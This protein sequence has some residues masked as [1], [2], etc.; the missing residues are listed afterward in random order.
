[1]VRNMSTVSSRQAKSRLGVREVGLGL[2]L[3][4]SAGLI[5]GWIHREADRVE[6]GALVADWL[7]AGSRTS[8]METVRVR[9]RSPA[10]IMFVLSSEC[11]YCQP[12]LVH[13]RSII[14]AV[15]GVDAAERPE[16]LFAAFE[17]I[18]LADR[19]LV[20]NDLDRMPLYRLPSVLRDQL[21]LDLV[22][23]TVVI[24][25]KSDSFTVW[26]GLLKESDLA[27]ILTVAGVAR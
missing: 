23:S 22:P 1:M 20:E 12:N 25:A 5:T 6:T 2:V 15:G 7:P 21:M 8:E 19:F 18:E 14:S 24:P 3:A 13:W 16:W 9:D 27:E 26:R 10:L 11:E 17:P 4:V